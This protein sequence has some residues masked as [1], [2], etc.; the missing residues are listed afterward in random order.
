LGDSE[1]NTPLLPSPPNQACSDETLPQ[2]ATDVTFRKKTACF[3]GLPGHFSALEKSKMVHD[4]SR[5]MTP[6]PKVSPGALYTIGSG[7]NDPQTPDIVS[8]TNY[9][10]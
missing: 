1:V 6:S 7:L 3:Q 5:V 9:H 8:I 4:V 10:K 2:A